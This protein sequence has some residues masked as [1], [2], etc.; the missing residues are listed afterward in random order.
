MDRLW[1]RMG[2]AF[3]LE[4]W[5]QACGAAGGEQYD[6]WTQQLADLSAD[7]I[8]RGVRNVL[9][10]SVDQVPTVQDFRTL[11]LTERHEP[12]APPE[13]ERKAAK[14]A[15]SKVQLAELA[16]QARIDASPKSRQPHDADVEHFIDSYH[17]C[18]LGLRWPG[19]KV[20]P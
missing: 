5:A 6:Q 12:P 11:C 20:A 7:Q 4:T 9:D 3:G 14:A 10:G 8:G 2:Q 15:P 19:G 17:K 16:R 13:R 1:R 18:S